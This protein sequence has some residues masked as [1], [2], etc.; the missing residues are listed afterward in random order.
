MLIIILSNF[1]Q[2]SLPLTLCETHLQFTKLYVS[3][4]LNSFNVHQINE[5]LASHSPGACLSVS[6]HL[7]YALKG[8]KMQ[9]SMKGKFRKL[10]LPNTSSIFLIDRSLFVIN[11]SVIYGVPLLTNPRHILRIEREG[12]GLS[13]HFKQL[14]F[15]MSYL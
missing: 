6:R 15:K 1:Q 7:V 3:R 8:L 9:S 2:F 14:S 13:A 10:I 5:T 11:I 4:L 12:R